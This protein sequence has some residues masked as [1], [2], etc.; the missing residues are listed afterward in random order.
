MSHCGEALQE[1]LNYFE[2][3]DETGNIFD[4]FPEGI[5]IEDAW[6]FFEPSPSNDNRKAV[7]EYTLSFAADN[8]VGFVDLS[9][10]PALQFQNHINS[11]SEVFSFGLWVLVESNVSDADA[12]GGRIV[13]TLTFSRAQGS[14]RRQTALP[15]WAVAMVGSVAPADAIADVMADAW[16]VAMADAIAPADAV[17]ARVIPSRENNGKLRLFAN[18]LLKEKKRQLADGDKCNICLEGGEDG[19]MV[20][21]MVLCPNLHLSCRHCRELWRVSQGL[22]K[23]N[24]PTCREQFTPY[25]SP[26]ASQEV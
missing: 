19:K 21:E 25:T 22:V 12:R 16:A 20:S 5:L 15:N 3:V 11:V 13:V 4:F 7:V 10:F 24:C 18:L 14:V 8:M 17:G 2:P 23:H 1:V 9:A 26:H 6:N